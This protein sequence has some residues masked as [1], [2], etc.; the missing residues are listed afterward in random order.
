MSYRIV[1]RNGR[2][3]PQWGENGRWVDADRT[4]A[5]IPEARTV[6]QAGRPGAV[7]DVVVEEG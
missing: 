7:A 6:A 2:Y 1:L 3:V 4:F 5:T